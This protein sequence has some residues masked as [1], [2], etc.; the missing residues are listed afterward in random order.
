MAM[1]AFALSGPA[2]ANLFVN[3]DFEQPLEVGWEQKLYSLAGSHSYDRWDTL[4]QPTPG[5]AARVYK[6]LA[7]Y[8]SLSQVVDVPG[9]D[10]D[11]SF[12]AR[13]R[14]GGGSS[15]CW[16]TAVVAISYLDEYASELGTSMFLLRDSYN[17]WRDTDTLKL[18]DIQE[19]GTWLRYELDVAQEIAD[20]LPGV[21]PDLVRKLEVQLF[22]YDNGT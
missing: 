9:A 2:V 1:V 17:T 14:I 19:N 21:N 3:G 4:G 8:A 18:H 12:E 5:H 13:L 22:A 20:N 6:Y 11:L 10:V 15:T 7:Y 16:P